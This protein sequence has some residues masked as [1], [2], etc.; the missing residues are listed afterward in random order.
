MVALQSSD[1]VKCTGNLCIPN[2]NVNQKKK[3]QHKYPNV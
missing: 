1:I 3:Q 2:V